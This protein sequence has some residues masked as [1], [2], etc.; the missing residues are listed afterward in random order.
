MPL[1]PRRLAGLAALLSLAA[2]C[3]DAVTPTYPD[4][5][6]AIALDAGADAPDLGAPDLGAPVDAAVADDATVAD[7]APPADDLPSADDAPTAADA[8]APVDAR[9]DVPRD[10]GRL[11]VCPPLPATCAAPAVDTPAFTGDGALLRQLMGLLSCAE[12]SV[13]A[14]LYE[15]L[16]ECLPDAILARLAAAPGL[17]VQ[18]V[19]D[20]ETCPRV[21]G[22]LMC[23]LSRLDGNPRVSLLP[24]GRAALMHHK[25]FVVD[26]AR[27]WVGSANSSETSYCRDA[28]DAVVIE[29]P[30]VVAAFEGEFQRMFRDH[31]FGPIAA[32]APATGG[33]YA[34][35]FSPRSPTS[36]P[37]RW[38][39]DMVGAIA[40]STATVDFVISAWTRTELSDAMIAARA[41]GVTVRGIV[42]REYLNDPP[43]VALL[44]AGVPVRSGDVHSKLLIID[45]QTVITG[46]ANWSAAAWA[47]NENSLWIRDAAAATAY[48]GYFTAQ[49]A[50]ATVPAGM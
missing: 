40:A 29:E 8:P 42:S 46:S 7:D 1:T 34:A 44:A 21:A 36:S 31:A 4:D 37:A 9:A 24:D 28:N 3:R 45:G 17:S 16:W 22:A 23:P 41:R 11:C 18:L 50:T 13:H 35:Y 20:D 39:T 5:L 38:F 10:A 26:G 2:G 30:A 15:T 12:T 49:Y 32:T 48:T 6:G 33:R 19:Y 43:A 27:V 14:A 25:Y 47:N